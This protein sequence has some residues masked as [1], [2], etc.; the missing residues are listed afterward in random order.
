MLDLQWPHQR[1]SEIHGGI[2][3]FAAERGWGTIIDECAYDT[4]RR[5]RGLQFDMT[6]SSREA[7]ARSPG[8]P[9]D[10]A[11]PSSTSGPGLQPVTC[12]WAFSPIRQRLAYASPT[13]FAAVTA[14][15]K[16]DNALTAR[17]IT[18]LNQVAGFGYVSALVPPNP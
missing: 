2:R 1:R 5:S 18:R 9:P 16:L 6:T 17:E 3:R 7:S 14:P 12:S 13:T 4:L 10:W 11:F 8:V 15:R